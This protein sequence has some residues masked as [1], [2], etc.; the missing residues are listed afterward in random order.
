MLRKLLPKMHRLYEQSH[1]A[2]EFQGFAA[3]LRATGYSDYL[4]RRHL[5]RL[6]K[7]LEFGDATAD[8]EWSVEKLKGAFDRYCKLTFKRHT[9]GYEATRRA[10]EQY[11]QAR[12]RLRRKGPPNDF[13]GPFRGEYRRH[14][15]EVRG[16]CVP[17]VAQHLSTVS[18]FIANALKRGESPALLTS[19]DIEE[20][21]SQKSRKCDRN[22]LQ[23]LVARLRAFLRYAFAH[24]LIPGRLDVIDTPRTYRGELPPRALP[25]PLVKRLLSSIDRSARAGWRNYTMLHLMAY[26]GLRASEVADLRVGSIDWSAKTCRVEQRK[27]HCDLILPLSDATMSLLRRYL[28]H[29][30][31]DTNHPQLFLRARNPAGRIKHTAVCNVFYR[32]AHRSGLSL[33]QYSSYSLRHAFAMRLLQRGVGVKAIGD[34]LGHHSLE[35]TCVY[36]RLNVSALRTI[37]LPLPP[38]K[39]SGR[40]SCER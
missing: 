16:F 25:W 38:R 35:A 26:Y 28:R 15:E 37:G 7:T 18:E 29:G 14:L 31:S 34:C 11:L 24:G 30:R 40:S 10:Y 6:R 17:T 33:Q 9:A 21:L 36:L 5:S 27:T 4:I 32:V 20:Y 19:Q 23:H 1:L 13:F 12:Q 3:W 2:A 8:K 39:L 22:T